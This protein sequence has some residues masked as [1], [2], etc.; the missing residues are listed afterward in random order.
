MRKWLTVFMSFTVLV[1]TSIAMLG[2]QTVYAEDVPA[3]SATSTATV[4]FTSGVSILAAP[5]FDFGVNKINPSDN[6]F[7][8]NEAQDTSSYGR[9]LVIKNDGGY[10]GWSVQAEYTNDGFTYDDAEKSKLTGSQMNWNNVQIQKLSDDGTW[11]N[12]TELGTMNDQTIKQGEP[13]QVFTTTNGEVGTYRLNFPSTSSASIS[14]PGDS[15]K[16]GTATTDMDWTLS[17]GPTS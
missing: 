11:A 2:H 13:T 6:T 14:I 7:D 8:L 12:T 16:V 1:A 9:S 15:Q 4:E 3:A 17:V 5:N 10:N